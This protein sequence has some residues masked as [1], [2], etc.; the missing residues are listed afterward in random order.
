MSRRK[1]PN[2]VARKRKQDLRQGLKKSDWI[3]WC[4]RRAQGK[5]ILLRIFKEFFEEKA[6]DEGPK[7]VHSKDTSEL[8]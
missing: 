2:L 5:R 6:D 7:R 1:I 8:D 4:E 3:E